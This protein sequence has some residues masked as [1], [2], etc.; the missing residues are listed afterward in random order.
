MFTNELQF[1]IEDLFVTNSVL[2]L[3]AAYNGKYPISSK[4]R[5]NCRKNLIKL[6]EEFSP[7]IVCPLGTVA[8]AATK[9]I[10]NHK[11][12]RLKDAVAREIQ[13]FTRILFPLYHT[14]RLAR[15]KRNGRPEELQ[16]QDWRKL[17]DLY[18]YLKQD[19]QSLKPS[20]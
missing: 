14:S 18:E 20:R 9:S 15:N 12:N 17:K 11:Y 2:C 5:L 8:L 3:P 4:L 10:D 19:N 1:K 6:I 13:W 7:I 16:R